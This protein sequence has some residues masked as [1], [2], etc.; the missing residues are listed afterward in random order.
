MA[1][2]WCLELRPRHRE[3]RDPKKLRRAL[4]PQM[5]AIVWFRQDLRLADNPAVAAAA[6][7]GPIVP[8][9]YSGGRYWS[10]LAPWRCEPMVVAPQPCASSPPA[11]RIG[12]IAG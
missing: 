6:C 1:S 10:C 8:I 11:R 9:L 5:T 4:K 7:C 3:T 12:T 2:G